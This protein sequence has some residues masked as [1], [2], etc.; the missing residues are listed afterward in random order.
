MILKSYQPDPDANA[1]R[2]EMQSKVQNCFHSLRIRK[3]LDDTEGIAIFPQHQ[4]CPQTNASKHMERFSACFP[5]TARV[6]I[7]FHFLGIFLQS[8]R[9]YPHLVHVGLSPDLFIENGL[10]FR[11]LHWRSYAWCQ[12]TS[13]HLASHHTM[14]L[15]MTWH[16][17]MPASPYIASAPKWSLIKGN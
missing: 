2:F 9:I 17:T 11:L 15:D 13:P 14:R 16:S 6:T 12:V 7:C 3:L 4:V 5:K 1:W 8:F 10:A